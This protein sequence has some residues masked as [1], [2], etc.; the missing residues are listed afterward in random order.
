MKFVKWLKNKDLKLYKY[1]ERST[2]GDSKI[3]G[4]IE[5]PMPAWMSEPDI[6]KLKKKAKKG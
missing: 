6:K 5:F 4:K 1:I 2:A 3:L